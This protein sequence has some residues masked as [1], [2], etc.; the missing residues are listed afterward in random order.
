MGETEHVAGLVREHFAT[1]PQ[2][3]HV[4]SGRTWFTI[5]GGIVAGE[6]IDTDAVA[7]RCLP[8]NEVLGRL[9]VEVFHCDRQNA[10]SIRGKA[11]R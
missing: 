1:S 10:E 7:E 11:S 6:A 5:K 8:E 3:E 2:Q 4:V 9:R